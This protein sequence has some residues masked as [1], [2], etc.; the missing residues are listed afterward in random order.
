MTY[1]DFRRMLI[2]FGGGVIL[3]TSVFVFIGLRSVPEVVGQLLFLIILFGAAYYGREGGI[4][5]AILATVIYAAVYFPTIISVGVGPIL[6]LI[7]IRAAIFGFTG[8]VGGEICSRIK[9]FLTEVGNQQFIDPNTR[10]FNNQY[11]ARVLK[12]QVENFD[13]YN[14]VF[15]VVLI[16]IS[17]NVMSYLRQEKYQHVLKEIADDILKGIRLVDEAGRV[18]EDQFLVLLPYTPEEGAKIAAKRV[19]SSL[20]KK[21]GEGEGAAYKILSFPANRPEVEHLI[22]QLSTTH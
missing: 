1:D 16:D 9:R 8:P 20:E 2:L 19:Y 10:L 17:D 14:T 22:Q 13:R 12:A 7:L 21:L 3:I 18:K 6:S 4:M 11:F 5:T 15:S